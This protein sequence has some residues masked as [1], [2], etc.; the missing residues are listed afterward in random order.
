MEHWLTHCSQPRT[1]LVPEE[2]RATVPSSGLLHWILA[3][4]HTSD[5]EILQ[6]SGLDAFFM[7]YL[8]TLL[9]VFF[10]LT[11]LI[12][13]ILIPLN[14]IHGKSGTGG[15]Q[16]LDT[17]SWADVRLTHAGFYW[18]YL[19]IALLVTTYVCYTIYAELEDYVRIRQLYLAS[20]QYRLREFANAILVTD[21]RD[22]F[23]ITSRLTQLYSV[24]PGGVCAVWI[25]RGPSKLSKKIKDRKRIVYTLER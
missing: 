19:F 7:R 9:R 23:L 14:F 24:F 6:K 11:L 15:A 18:I 1:Y 3:V 17:L 13:P 25:N 2:Q 22:R 8:S 16:G 5:S 20:P 10:L 21:I 4:F 12:I